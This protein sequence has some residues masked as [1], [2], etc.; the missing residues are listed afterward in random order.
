MG[1]FWAKM[2]Y[3]VGVLWP[4]KGCF[5]PKWDACSSRFHTSRFHAPP[6]FTRSVRF[7]FCAPLTVCTLRTSLGAI[8]SYTVHHPLLYTVLSFSH[9]YLFARRSFTTLST[10]LTTPLSCTSS[11]HAALWASRSFF[12][13]RRPLH[14]AYFFAR[15]LSAI[16][17]LAEVVGVCVQNKESGVHRDEEEP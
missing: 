17:L 12:F 16:F 4:K 8:S 1:G 13:A 7:Y 6:V 2:G 9:A 11:L 14:G 15:L 5:G 3:Y 10:F